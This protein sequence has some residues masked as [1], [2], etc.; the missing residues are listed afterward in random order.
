VYQLPNATG[1]L[2]KINS[3][4]EKGK[5]LAYFDIKDQVGLILD[6]VFDDASGQVINYPVINAPDQGIQRSIILT[7]DALR[8][9]PLRNNEPYYFAVTAYSFSS[10]PT[11]VPRTLESDPTRLTI[12]PKQ[13]YGTRLSGTAGDTITVTHGSGTASSNPL[14]RI[15]NPLLLNGHT[16]EVSVT[17]KDSVYNAD[18]DSYLPNPKWTL[19]DKTASRAIF[20]D[21][22]VYANITDNI[23]FADGFSFLMLGSPFWIAGQEIAS[24]TYN[25]TEGIGN[26]S[27]VNAT[28]SIGPDFFGSSLMPWEINKTVEIRFST[29]TKSKGYCYLRGGTPNYAYQGYFDSPITIWDVT[30]P[31]SPRQLQYWFVEQNGGPFKDN[32]WTPGDAS[33]D[34]EYLFISNETYS[35]T[36]NANYT[37]DHKVNAEAGGWPMLYAIWFTRT[38]ATKPAWNN[39]DVLKINATQ[40]VT[41]NDKW[42]FSPVPPTKNSDQAAADIAKITA[43]PNPYYGFQRLEVNRFNRFITFTNLPSDHASTIRIF[44]VGGQHVRTLQKSADGLQYVQWDLRTEN[45]MPAASGMYVVYVDIPDLGKSKV[46]K[47]AVIQEQEVLDV[48]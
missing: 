26:F 40:I 30:N 25:G 27:S 4:A 9:K 19:T 46:L 43:F 13:I 29:T 35:E 1:E 32:Q 2:P 39:G 11:A 33:S 34:R 37:G 8:G 17:V 48:F 24:V 31:A 7:E 16:Y 28:P 5:I 23:K 20:A 45:N 22:S 38:D 41:P 36:P 47:I 18:A 21:Q 44:N 14:V 10:S 15:V 12:F 42:T 6:D 3:S